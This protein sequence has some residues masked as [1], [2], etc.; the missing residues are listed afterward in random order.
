MSHRDHAELSPSSSDRWLTCPGSVPLSRGHYQENES[1]YAVEGTDHHEV[2]A[3]CL[4]EGWDAKQLVGKPMLSGAILGED[5]AQHVQFYLDAVRGIVDTN[6]GSL[7]VEDDLPIGFL[8]GE[9]NAAGKADALIIL[10]SPE[11]VVIDLKFGMGVEVDAKE[12]SQLM[13]YAAAALEKHQL[14]D[15]VE[16]VR[17]IIVQPRVPGE[18]VKEWVCSTKTLKLFCQLVKV[19][20]QHISQLVG[21]AKYLGGAN[22]DV[23]REVAVEQLSPSDKACRF[24]PAKAVCPALEQRVRWA[25]STNTDGFVNAEILQPATPSTE[26][27]RHLGALMDLTDLVED[28]MTAVR[29]KVESELLAGHPVLGKDGFYKLVRGRMG[30]R[31]WTDTSK[32]IS[33]FEEFKIDENDYYVKTLVTPAAAEKKFKK[34]HVGRLLETLQH[35]TSQKEGS[36]SVAHPTDKRPAVVQE[37]A[38][39]GFGN[40]EWRSLI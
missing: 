2:A 1:V 38:T 24:C 18:R 35:S 22:K 26:N 23:M 7:V 17:L 15:T 8:T 12:N 5:G 10:P 29:A 37:P 32:V 27:N 31:Q 40:E 14:W 19:K 13:I 11:I 39:T 20:S 30:A 33:V 25:V 6:K 21:G 3:L 28:W 16:N 36:L 34:T 4:E 9:Q